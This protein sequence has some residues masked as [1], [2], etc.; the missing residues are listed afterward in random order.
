MYALAI[1]LGRSKGMDDPLR[2]RR[3]RPDIKV[4]RVV[5]LYTFHDTTDKRE[6]ESEQKR[7]TQ[8]VQNGDFFSGS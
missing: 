3:K 4:N 8:I 6:H 1:H 7:K 5:R 2:V